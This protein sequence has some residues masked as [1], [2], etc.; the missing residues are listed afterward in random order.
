MAAGKIILVNG[1]S[2]CGKT[3]LSRALQDALEEPFWHYSIDH[4]RD[5]G[6]LPS[7]RIGTGEFPWQT[8]RT[9]FFDGLH[10]CLPV[11]AEAG[12]N[13]IVDHIIDTKAWLDRLVV[14]LGHLD[15]FF[16]GVHCPLAELERREQARGD[17]PHGDARND[18][19]IV[20]GHC[21]YD[22]EVDGTMPGGH[23]AAAVIDAWRRRSLPS[24]FAQ[25]KQNVRD[26][27]AQD[28]GP[29]D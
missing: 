7:A 25:M 24:G 10:G 21:V 28:H 26:H 8:M 18:H 12:N 16:V 9:A 5:A 14:L 19:G 3:T 20:H 17:R 22:F 15:V 23:A 2:S 27:G 29:L 6:V 13:L 1:A 11:L 4:I